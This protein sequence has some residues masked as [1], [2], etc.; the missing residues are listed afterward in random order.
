M[1]NPTQ[2]DFM[3]RPNDVIYVSE[4]KTYQ[5]GRYNDNVSKILSPFT[6]ISSAFI[7]FSL[8]RRVK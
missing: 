3:L 4:L 8:V 7:S 2:H 6:N 1:I 5:L